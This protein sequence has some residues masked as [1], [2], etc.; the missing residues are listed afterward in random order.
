MI[1]T[2]KCQLK[3]MHNLKAESSVLFGAKLGLKQGGY[4]DKCDLASC[5]R[6][7]KFLN[8]IFFAYYKGNKFK[9]QKRESWKH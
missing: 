4:E 6:K 9:L 7:C 2:Y 3:K 8:E 5:L 1:L